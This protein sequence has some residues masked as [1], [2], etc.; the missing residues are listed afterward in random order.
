[1]SKYLSSLDQFRA[2]RRCNLVTEGMVLFLLPYVS[3]S[4]YFPD[5]LLFYLLDILLLADHD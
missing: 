5:A 1:M 4:R 2:G 3:F